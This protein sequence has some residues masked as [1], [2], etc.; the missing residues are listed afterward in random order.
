M[1]SLNDLALKF[2]F[3]KILIPNAITAAAIF[4]GFV[5]ILQIMQGNHLT[6][7][8][9][10]LIACFLDLWDGRV[11]RLINATSDFGIQ[12]DS[13]ADVVNYGAAPAL[14]FYTLYFESWGLFGL[15]ISFLPLCCAAIRLARFNV[16]AGDD[17]PRKTYFEGLPTT[18]AACL[19]SAFVILMHDVAPT[20]NVSPTAALLMIMLAF[21]MV[22]TVQYEKG[23]WL[24]P[25]YIFKTHRIFTGT[26]IVVT[27]I[28]FPKVA[29]FMWGMLYVLFGLVRSMFVTLKKLQ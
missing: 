27:L 28:A 7:A 14:L 23:N 12:F 13:L 4:A 11:A 16:Q 25:R 6:A 18:M 21:L 3:P 17:A 5:A 15:L 2:K 10:I 22:S 8:W 19:L 9:C 1:T 24:S 20:L 26:V 29:F